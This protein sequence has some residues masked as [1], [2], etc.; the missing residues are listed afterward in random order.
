MQHQDW[1]ADSWAVT[2]IQIRTEGAGQASGAAA[3]CRPWPCA[4]G[5][6]CMQAVVMEACATH[7]GVMGTGR[8]GGPGFEARRQRVRRR[9]E[10]EGDSSRAL[11]HMK[12]SPAVRPR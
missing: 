11:A 6:Q 10:I 12:Y 4:C 2:Y 1:W 9:I 3:Q 5:A 7:Q 8:T